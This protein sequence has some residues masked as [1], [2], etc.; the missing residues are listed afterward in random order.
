MFD[1][2]S[3]S[4]LV[5]GHP[6]SEDTVTRAAQQLH[7]A[8]PTSTMLGGLAGGAADCEEGDKCVIYRVRHIARNL[9][10]VVTHPTANVSV[11]LALLIRRVCTAWVER[12]IYLIMIPHFW[13]VQPDA[14]SARILNPFRRFLER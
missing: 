8:Y 3:T 12:Y 14:L 2:D 13:G 5:F 11:S 4:L 1:G 10:Y 7:G 6:S 9:K